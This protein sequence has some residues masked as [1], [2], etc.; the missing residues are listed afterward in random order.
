[1]KGGPGLFPV[2]VDVEKLKRIRREKAEE[3]N[4]VTRSTVTNNRAQ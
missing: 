2:Q 4:C 1:M 3:M